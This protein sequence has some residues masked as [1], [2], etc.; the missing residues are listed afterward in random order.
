MFLLRLIPGSSSGPLCFFRP[1]CSSL[2]NMAD[3][4]CTVVFSHKNSKK[5]GIHMGK[6]IAVAVVVVAVGA[7]AVVAKKRK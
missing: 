4:A 1:P 7:A 2:K 5:G 6:I 3:T